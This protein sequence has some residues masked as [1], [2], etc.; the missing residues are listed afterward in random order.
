MPKTLLLC[1]CLGSQTVDADKI[2]SASGLTCSRVYTALC[3]KQID[4]AAQAMTE[5]DVTIACQ[6][7]R[8]RF[9]DLAEEIGSDVPSFVDIRDRAG[10]ND[11]GQDAAPKMAAL[12]AEAHLSM[13]LPR[14]LDV[15]SE[16]TCLI[17]GRTETSLEAARRLCDTLAVTVLLSTDADIAEADPRYDVVSGKL[18][19]AK[20]ALGNFELVFDAL[21]QRIPGGRGAPQFTPPR[22]RAAS[23]CDIILDLSGEASLFPAP[24]KREGYLRADPGSVP[25]VAEAVRT[26]G[27]LVGTFEKPLYVRL[28]ESL[29][30]HS[31]AGQV[32]C[33]NCLDL[34]PT[35]AITPDG[36]HVAVDPLICA[37][38]GACSAACPSGAITYDAPPVDALFRRLNTLAETYRRAGGTAPRL[39]VHDHDHGAEMISLHARYGSGL[40]VDVVPFAIESLSVFGHAEML[41]A[42][43]G[44]FAAVDVLLSPR[45]ERDALSAQVA[46]ATA[47]SGG[48]PIRLLDLD[49]PDALEGALRPDTA[50][51]PL[52]AAILPIGTRRQ[53]ARLAGK[54]L[55]PDA[56]MLPLP[57]NAPYG[58]VLVDTDACTLC[59]SCVS[60]CPS[61]ALGDNPDKPQLRF[62]ED[63]CLQC[64]LCANICPEAAITLEPRLNLEDTAFNQV[65][66]NEEEPF[67]CIECGTLFGVKSTV[68]KITEKLAGKHAMFANPQAAKMI[69]MCD[70]CRI[71]AQY[72][73][74]DN[75]F[76]GKERPRVRTT[77]DYFGK[78]RDH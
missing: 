31:R 56:V 60:L 35:G 40:P 24:H 68:E 27:E 9:E 61:G 1:D 69:Q 22:D 55:N 21:R 49:S 54:S 38:C 75:P 23:Q 3:T 25:A 29:C 12:V 59:L 71:N 52:T 5:G 7:E 44:G 77:E 57:D 34:C 62:Q 14:A 2:A 46:L 50:E 19:S 63:A 76:Q 10:W 33:T 43:A 51:G 26:A 11:S 64:G 45:S 4:I 41:A 42:L 53:V 13:P 18:R 67:A 28:T 74:Q 65:V 32:A 48:R 20:G 30:A 58:A 73:S 17:I 36:E 8:R 6:Q 78:R 70:N 72:H 39:L 15:V 16:G 47:M 66:L 37:G